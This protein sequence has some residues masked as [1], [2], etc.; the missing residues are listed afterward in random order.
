[1]CQKVGRKNALSVITFHVLMRLGLEETT[2]AINKHKLQVFLGKIYNG[3]NRNVEYHNDMH[4]ADV[5]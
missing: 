2:L 1:M 3:Y 4:A 5:V